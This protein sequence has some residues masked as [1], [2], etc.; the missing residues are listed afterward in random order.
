MTL[1]LTPVLRHRVLAESTLPAALTHSGTTV[2][3]G[4]ALTALAAQISV[5]IPGSPV[6]VTGQTFA[7]LA[8][9]AALGPA[10]GLAAQALYLILGA[11]GLPVFA[12]GAHGVQQVVGATG[13]YL[14][15][16]LLASLITGLGARRGADRTSLRA[17]PLMV[18]ASMAIYLTGATWLAVSTGMSASQAVAVGVVPFLLGDALK[19]LLAAGLL[20]GAWRLLDRAE[21]RGGR[22]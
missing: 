22:R 7:V 2:V 13:G 9:A 21:R 15:G 8:T 12:H 5:P 18:L 20:P 16:F 10:R 4:T 6:P 11:I 1:A 19:A 17:L 3:L 14:L